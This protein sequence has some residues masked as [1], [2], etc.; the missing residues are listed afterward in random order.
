VSGER[1]TTVN[2]HPRPRD[3]PTIPGEFQVAGPGNA[4]DIEAVLCARVIDAAI[5]PPLALPTILAGHT[6][7]ALSMWARHV[8]A[9]GKCATP[10]RCGCLSLRCC[11]V[12]RT[13]ILAIPS[14]SRAA[15][16]GSSQ[17]SCHQL[18]DASALRP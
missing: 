11:P 4:I 10:S 13:W 8:G 9:R 7:L 5:D 2:Y 17:P 15:V 3:Y 1:A 18:T 16:G 12:T 6:L 14:G